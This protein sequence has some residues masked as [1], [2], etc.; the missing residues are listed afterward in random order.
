[1]IAQ[2][3][4]EVKKLKAEMQTLGPTASAAGVAEEMNEL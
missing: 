4:E 1:L 2:N 3:E